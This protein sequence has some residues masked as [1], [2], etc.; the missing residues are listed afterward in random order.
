MARLVG[1]VDREVKVLR[2]LLRKDSELDVKLLEVCASDLLVELL[3]EHVDAERKL[4]RV[5]PESDLGKDLVGERA[6]HDERGM[7]GGTTM[8][9]D[10]EQVTN[11]TQSNCDIPQVDKTTLSQE[12]DV[13]AISHGEAIDLGFDVDN[14]L[15]VGL[16]PGNINLNVKVTDARICSIRLP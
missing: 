12:D 7:T 15:G 13:A 10:N 3:G 6:G 2:L 5:S 16:Q 11:W 9:I 4:A 8:R 1:A 14:L